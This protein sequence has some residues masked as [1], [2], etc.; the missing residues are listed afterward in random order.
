MVRFGDV[1]EELKAAAREQDVNAVV[2]G[3]PDE[4]ESI[5]DADEIKGL[6]AEIENETH[7][8]VHVL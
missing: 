6:A 7:A 3:R 8:Q 4:G 1:R 2:L 5:F